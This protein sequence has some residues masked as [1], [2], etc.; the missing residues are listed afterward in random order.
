MSTTHSALYD[1]IDPEKLRTLS[2]I[3]EML[4]HE[5]R[6]VDVLRLDCEGCEWGVLKQLACSDDSALVDQLMVE[7]HFQKNLGIATDEDLLIAADAIACLEEKKWGLTSM[8]FSGCDPL[9]ADYVPRMNTII[10]EELRYMLL[11]ATFRR[12]PMEKPLYKKNDPTFAE[13]FTKREVYH[14]AG[15]FSIETQKQK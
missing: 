13:R 11:F 5:Q 9:D 14:M 12:V 10:K 15:H 6:Q 7:L 4:G 1:A 3:R 8:E 2:D